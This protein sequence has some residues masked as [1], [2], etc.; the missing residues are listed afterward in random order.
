MLRLLWNLSN[1]V[2]LFLRTYMPTNILLDALR[3]R[4]GLKWGVPA[5]LIAAPYLLGA[6]LLTVWISDGG[7]GWLNLLV[8]LFIWNALKFLVNGPITLVLLV[9]ARTAERRARR[10]AGRSMAN[11]A[12]SAEA[13]GLSTTNA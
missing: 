6:W 4:R 8:L 7:P 10:S 9:R 5:M 1:R 2:R 11:R 3:T 13:A 12:P